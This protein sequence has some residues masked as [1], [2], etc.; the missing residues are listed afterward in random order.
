MVATPYTCIAPMRRRRKGKRPAMSDGDTMDPPNTR[1][2]HLI[3]VSKRLVR[4]GGTSPETLAVL[5]LPIVLTVLRNDV[6]GRR[7]SMLKW[8]DIDGWF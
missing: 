3:S 8:E 6:I 7:C 5:E 1:E 2:R 4:M